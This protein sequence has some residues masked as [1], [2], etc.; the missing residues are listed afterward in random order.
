MYDG[1]EHRYT[2]K[3]K[4]TFEG[5]L[6]FERRV[7][8]YAKGTAEAIAKA[9]YWATESFPGAQWIEL[10]CFHSG[11]Q[12]IESAVEHGAIG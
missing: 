7:A 12:S 11:Y 6:P 3:V 2:V 10:S 4:V 8:T 1:R 5:E 9:D